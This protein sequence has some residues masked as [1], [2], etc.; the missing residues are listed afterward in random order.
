MFRKLERGH[1]K[2]SAISYDN[3]LNSYTT[4]SPTGGSLRVLPGRSMA[5]A[6]LGQGCHVVMGV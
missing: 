6:P 3:A 5:A 4:L 2:I 1:K